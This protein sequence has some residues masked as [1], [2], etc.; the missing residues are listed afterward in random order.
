M[1]VESDKIA[2]LRYVVTRNWEQLPHISDEHPDL[3][4]FVAGEDYEE[5]LSLAEPYYDVRTQGDGY[6]P[7][8]IEEKLLDVPREYKGFKVPGPE[9]YFLS[10]Y[11]HNAVHKKGDPYGERLRDIFLSWINPTRPFDAGVNFYD[12]SLN[13]YEF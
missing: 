6:Y 13:P 4:I 12:S 2:H 1:I 7:K 11:Y 8:Y 9:A 3:D 5:M 10:L